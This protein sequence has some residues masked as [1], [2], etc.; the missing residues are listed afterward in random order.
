MAHSTPERL[1]CHIVWAV[2]ALRAIST[3]LQLGRGAGKLHVSGH[4]PL[5]RVGAARRVS[6][7][8]EYLTRHA[9][10]WKG[11]KVAPSIC[12]CRQLDLVQVILERHGSPNGMQRKGRK[13]GPG[14]SS[15]H[16]HE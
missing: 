8:L 3:A 6:N 7:P 4:D 13:E 11:H 10:R 12:S 2:Y 9:V 15:Y 14:D 16:V 1:V 5:V